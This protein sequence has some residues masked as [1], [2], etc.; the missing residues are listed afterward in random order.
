MNVM[1]NNPMNYKAV[2]QLMRFDVPPD[3]E[4]VKSWGDV[5]LANLFLVSSLEK[6]AK[7]INV[8]ADSIMAFIAKLAHC[9]LCCNAYMTGVLLRLVGHKFVYFCFS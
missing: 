1:K 5:S 3:F 8:G 2:E 4:V 9:R 7:F 6:G